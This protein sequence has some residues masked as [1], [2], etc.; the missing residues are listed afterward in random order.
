[1]ASATEKINQIIQSLDKEITTLR[2]RKEVKVVMRIDKV[3]PYLENILSSATDDI[4]T[5]KFDLTQ[6]ITGSCTLSY[7]VNGQSASAGA[8]VLKYGDKLKITATPSSH[9]LLKSLKVNGENF[10]SGSTLTVSTDIA[11]TVVTELEK[12]NLVVTAGENSSVSVTRNGVEVE[13]GTDAISYGDVLTISASAGEGYELSTLT[14]NGDDFISGQTHTV[15]GNVTVVSAA[16]EVV[17][18]DP[19]QPQPEEPQE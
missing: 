18:P 12:F 9:Y 5:R 10:V 16:T 15:S 2:A 13:A 19:E 4:S 3:I 1:M 6:D 17:T 7:E 11:V 8:N 14:V